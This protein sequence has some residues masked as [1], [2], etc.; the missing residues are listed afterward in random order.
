MNAFAK[1]YLDLNGITIV[2]DQSAMTADTD[3]FFETLIG[4][5]KSVSG[6]LV[7]K[8]PT[9]DF[10]RLLLHRGINSNDLAALVEWADSFIENHLSCIT[11]SAL[12]KRTNLD[13]VFLLCQMGT[14]FCISF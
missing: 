13:I 10:P 3:A 2:A 14:F 11:R 7:L 5:H 6:I 8:K 4:Y 1:D 12:L 9:N